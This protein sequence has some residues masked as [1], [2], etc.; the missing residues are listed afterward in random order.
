MSILRNVC[1]VLGVIGFMAFGPLAS[2]AQADRVILKNITAAPPLEESRDALPCEGD[3]GGG[4]GGSGMCK[5][6][7]I[8]V[9]I[10][11]GLSPDAAMDAADE[12]LAPGN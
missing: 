10:R 4:G 9:L 8:N 11:Y 1:L 3:G 2:S 5:P 6:Y 12:I 7:I